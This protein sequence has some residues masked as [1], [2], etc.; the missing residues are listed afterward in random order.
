M[1]NRNDEG[2][3]LL[4]L[5]LVVVVAAVLGGVYW[6]SVHLGASFV[7]TAKGL[8][9]SF[10]SLMASG[11]LAVVLRQ[12]G[13]SSWL[14]CFWVTPALAWPAWWPALDSIATGGRDPSDAIAVAMLSE[15]SLINSAWVTWGGEVL[16]LGLAASAIVSVWKARY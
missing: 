7:T 2:G 1:G 14:N 9:G 11:M 10:G 8:G 6:V 12:F 16:F 5:G 3:G 13:F 4:L 15:P